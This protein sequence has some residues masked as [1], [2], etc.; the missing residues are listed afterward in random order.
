MKKF[1][2]IAAFLFLISSV[3]TP[4]SA[5]TDAD[6]LAGDPIAGQHQ[7]TDT[8]TTELGQLKV[9]KAAGTGVTKG[10][11]FTFSVGN[12]AYSVPAG[13]CVLA[14]QYSLNTQVTIRE[15]I[16][17][18]YFVENI[19]VE[20]SDR[21]VSKNTSLGEAV[22][23]IGSG[24][25]EVSFRN[26]TSTSTSTKTPE[27]PTPPQGY[28]QIC[29]QAEGAGVSGYFMFRFA[30]QTSSVPVGSCSNLIFNLTPGTLTVTE[31]ARAG[32]EISDIYTIPADRLVSKDIHARTATVTILPSGGDAS[33]QTVVVFVNRRAESNPPTNTPTNTPTSTPSPT[34]TGTPTPTT[35]AT[36]T[37]T[38]TPSSTPSPTETGTPTS[39]PSPTETGTPTPT[40]T[41]PPTISDIVPDAG[42]AS[43][44][45]VVVITGTNLTGTTGVTFGDTAI[46]TPCIIDSDTQITC[47]T[48]PH[49][50]GVVDV[51]VT[52]PG[53]SITV[54]GGFTYSPQSL[55]DG[56]EGSMVVES[57]RNIL[58]VGR[59]Y[60]GPQIASYDGYSTGS[61]EV[62][63]PMLFRQAFG[64]AYN[65]EFYIQNID[66]A[67]T[68][69]FSI[70]FFDIN[71]VLS[72]TLNDSLARFSS[73]S[74]SVT[75]LGCLPVGWVGGAVI[76]SDHN[77]VAVGH[78]LIGTQEMTYN[79]FFGGSTTV[80]TPMLFNQAFGGDYVS[81]LYIQNL[82]PTQTATF[83][84]E[85]Y[86]TAGNLTCTMANQQRAPL[87]AKGFWLPTETCV[88]D[89]WAGGVLIES[90][91]P[92]A[93]VART[94]VGAEITS[95]SGIIQVGPSTYVPMLF[96][97]AFDGSYMAALYVQNVDQSNSA[98]I[99][100]DFFSSNGTLTCTM[101]GTLS[102]GGARGYWL[103]AEGCMP[104]G[105]A[106]SAVITS[107][108]DIVAVAR[109]HIGTEVTT[110][111]GLASGGL[112]AY[113]PMLFKNGG[114]N[115]DYNSALYIQ[116]LENS[117]ADVSIK[118]FDTVGNLSCVINETF[119]ATSV[120]GY[121]LPTLAICP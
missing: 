9:C 46:T 30:T 21:T 66:S 3:A 60:F 111:P 68:A 32:Y 19:T 52:T 100:I 13:Y 78:P 116:N 31:D 53:G 39:T 97:N 11:V 74:Y 105:W 51:T 43:G 96:K 91:R 80:Y 50:S 5:N 67:Q 64:G 118:L 94:H 56:W 113:L 15:S 23:K 85:F 12:T 114:L 93:A 61:T 120:K 40:T 41:A 117:P 76:T 58:T 42:P 4:V 95:Y 72:C 17:A 83:S 87:A 59:P 44:G 62:Y 34:E 2:M 82:D 108:T 16:P 73:K 18:G 88:P 25:T 48:P 98:Q 27:P 24:I 7:Y 45:T 47:T 110:Y 101:T 26:A 6:S 103:P 77:L 92:L 90:D 35:T 33:L 49:T 84:L 22:V 28:M 57:N 115:H 65:S 106:G 63:L 121:W 109:P 8:S 1:F 71:G 107:N 69:N 89:G 86:D 99:T 70:Q 54:P 36:G 79:S 29:K 10:D 75:G 37:S 14:G 119:E 81:A 55:P 38:S 20:P 112:T 104:N 102:P